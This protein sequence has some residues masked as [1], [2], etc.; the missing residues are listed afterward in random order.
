MNKRLEDH[1]RCPWGKYEGTPMEDIPASYLLWVEQQDPPP[2]PKMQAYI[3][4]A[5]SALEQEVHHGSKLW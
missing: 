5:R 3:D 4:W 1:D 2:P